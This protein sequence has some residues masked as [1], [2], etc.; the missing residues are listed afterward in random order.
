MFIKGLHFYAGIILNNIHW[1][2]E[3]TIPKIKAQSIWRHFKSQNRPG[4]RDFFR[5][6]WLPG[7]S[8][9]HHHL[10]WPGA[11]D[12]CRGILTAENPGNYFRQRNS[13]EHSER[14]PGLSEI[15][16]NYFISVNPVT[17]FRHQS[18]GVGGTAFRWS[19][20]TKW[21]IVSAMAVLVTEGRPPHPLLTKYTVFL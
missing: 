2:T 7:P 11:V 15:K 12:D 5:I 8:T 10:H 14:V 21:Y 4:H 18:K 16:P 6:L 3:W 20:T 17:L 19:L 9:D 13:P 1:L